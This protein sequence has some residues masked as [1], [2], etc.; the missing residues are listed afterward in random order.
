MWRKR[1]AISFQDETAVSMAADDW[2]IREQG[3][4]HLMISVKL[5]KEEVNCRTVIARKY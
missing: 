5:H 2:G 4:R 1:H 3:L